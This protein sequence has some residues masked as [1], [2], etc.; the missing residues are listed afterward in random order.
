MRNISQEKCLEEYLVN[1]N[2]RSIFT[3]KAK[4]RIYIRR[5]NKGESIVSDGDNI[6]AM[7]IVIEGKLKVI[8]SSLEG[9]STVIDYLS[10]GDVSG[11]I[12][13]FCKRKSIHT[14]VA[15]GKVLLLE[16]PF[17][18]IDKELKNHAPFLLYMCDKLSEKMC[19][20]SITRSKQLL[21]PTKVQI[22]KRIVELVE[23]Y[24]NNTIPINHTEVAQLIGNSDR[25]VRRVM[26]ELMKE[27]VIEKQRR[28]YIT[29]LDVTE[30]KN[31]INSV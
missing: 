7:S 10:E 5:I 13:Y 16:I 21:M 17:H 24:K 19:N 28:G 15:M 18:I 22:C 23:K 29:I 2:F 12:E 14:V 1:Y 9:K 4:E 30:L 6:E 3:E 25:H 8:P 31:I 11:D 26:A 27:G 20:S